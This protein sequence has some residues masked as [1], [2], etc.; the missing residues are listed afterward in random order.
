MKFMDVFKKRAWRLGSEKGSAAVPAILALAGAVLVVGYVVDVTRASSDAARMKQ[1]TD[2]AAQA[3]SLAYAK[4]NDTDVLGMAERY[5]RANLGTDEAQTARQLMVSTE[6]VT[7]GDYEGFRVTASFQVKP[8][9]L[10]GKAQSVKVASAAVAVYSPIEVSFVVPSTMNESQRDMQA[11]RDIG[12]EFWDVLIDGR[13]DRWMALVPYSDGVNVW[14]D[15]KKTQRIRSWAMPD[16]LSPLWLRYVTSGAGVT[17]LASPR[18]PDVRKK[19]LHVRRGMLPGEIFYWDTQAPQNSFEVSAQTCAGGNCVMANYPGGWPYVTWQGPVLPPLGDGLT[20]PVDNRYIAADNTVPLTAVLPLT[21]DR[22]AFTDRLSDLVPD[23]DEMSH[24]IN[25]NLAMGWG[26]MALSPAFRGMNGW[27]DLDHPFDFS[28]DGRSTVKAVVMLANLNGTLV[29]IDM[30]SNN[31]Y[32][33]MPALG[34]MADTKDSDFAR[35]RIEDLC[36]SFKSHRDMNFYL[37]MIPPSTQDSG[38]QRFDELWPTLLACR[39][40][41][42]DVQ[43][44][45]TV[46]FADGKHQ[47]INQLKRI[48]SDLETKSSYARLIE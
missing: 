4:D 41:A 43:Q 11:I 5:V 7:W 42:G 45:K 48:A 34:G 10:G 31:H 25:M 15:Q 29:D 36:T 21:D 32:L 2:A 18:M 12:E 28:E 13:S 40:S 6:P 1:A 22:D 23:H 27:G 38:Q 8:S 46:S 9:L 30:D 16:R 17:S 44:V 14:D 3:V 24:A 20:G 35:Q 37:L 39:R 47:F 33:D 26:A 19:I